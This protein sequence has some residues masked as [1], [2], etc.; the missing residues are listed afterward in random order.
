MS[1]TNKISMVDEMAGVVAIRHADANGYKV[2][3]SAD[4]ARDPKSRWG[5]FAS[6][7][8]DALGFFADKSFAN[9]KSAERT[10][11]KYLEE[12]AARMATNAAQFVASTQD[13]V[14]SHNAVPAGFSW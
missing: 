8:G 14:I 2:Q 7:E 11:V 12:R 10:A 9:R 4:D 3:I 6:C 5:A 13:D 1:T